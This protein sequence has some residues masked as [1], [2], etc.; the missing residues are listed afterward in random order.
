MT[1]ILTRR[2]AESRSAVAGA[3]SADVVVVGGGPAATWAAPGAAEHHTE[4]RGTHE[5]EDHPA[6]DPAQ[7]HRLVV[8]G[9]EEVRVRTDQVRPALAVAS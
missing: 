9:L 7:W 2:P 8:G 1:R 5:R 6:A 4:S 3:L